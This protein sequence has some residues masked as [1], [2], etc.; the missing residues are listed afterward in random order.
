MLCRVVSFSIT[1]VHTNEGTKDPRVV[2]VWDGWTAEEFGPWAFKEEGMGEV[3]EVDT[4]KL[5]GLTVL[6]WAF[7]LAVETLVGK[8]PPIRRRFF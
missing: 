5:R 7:S 8:T 3:I 1:Y 2:A 6:S 4:R